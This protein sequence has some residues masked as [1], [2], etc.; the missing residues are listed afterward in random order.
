MAADTRPRTKDMVR[1]STGVTT[2]ELSRQADCVM[3]VM[4]ITRLYDDVFT[5]L[6]LTKGNCVKAMV[7]CDFIKNSCDFIKN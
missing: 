6:E 2:S 1:L 5:I 3:L 4:L 7:L